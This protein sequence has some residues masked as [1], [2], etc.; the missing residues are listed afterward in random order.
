MHVRHVSWPSTLWTGLHTNSDT[1]AKRKGASV[2]RSLSLRLRARARSQFPTRTNGPA[3][4][5]SSPTSWPLRPYIHTTGGALRFTAFHLSFSDQRA[6]ERVTRR[7]HHPSSRSCARRTDSASAPVSSS[8]AASAW[9]SVS[10]MH[11]GFCLLFW[12]P[13]CSYHMSHQGINQSKAAKA[14]NVHA[15]LPTFGSDTCRPAGR[16]EPAHPRAF[17]FYQLFSVMSFNVLFSM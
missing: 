1:E 13:L 12:M 10:T 16:P 3:R 6:S 14:D 4:P 11:D 17:M 15:L 7:R 9:M 8:Y 5:A 2:R